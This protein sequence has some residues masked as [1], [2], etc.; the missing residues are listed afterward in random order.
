MPNN[1]ILIIMNTMTKLTAVVKTR[2]ELSV[3]LEKI[4]KGKKHLFKFDGKQ[5]AQNFPNAMMFKID[6]DIPIFSVNDK[7]QV[8]ATF[9]VYNTFLEKELEEAKNY[10][11][12][13]TKQRQNTAAE[14]DQLKTLLATRQA[15]TTKVENTDRL[16]E[17]Q[18]AADNVPF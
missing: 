16:L 10:S 9:L 7:Q 1:K 13:L 4:C 6:D 18:T 15:R 5:R 11:A 2:T 14:F 12:G 17:E 3:R 8:I